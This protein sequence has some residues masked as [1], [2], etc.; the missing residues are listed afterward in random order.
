MLWLYH[1]ISYMGFDYYAS[2]H[3]DKM[4]CFSLIGITHGFMTMDTCQFCALFKRTISIIILVILTII[5]VS[6]YIDGHNNK[7]NHRS[8]NRT[9]CK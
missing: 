2:Y 3:Q 7:E 6:F 9:T 5:L 1:Y 4:T 8:S